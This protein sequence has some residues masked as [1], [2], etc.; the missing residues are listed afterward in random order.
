MCFVTLTPEDD[1]EYLHQAAPEAKV[2][3]FSDK[4]L[5]ARGITLRPKWAWS[6]SYRKH[7][8]DHWQAMGR[9]VVLP[10]KGR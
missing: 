5:K 7:V 3:R 9:S 4:T 10:M 2:E 6:D 8:R 1:M